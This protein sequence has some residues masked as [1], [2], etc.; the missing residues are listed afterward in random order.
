MTDF[1][2][3][4]VHHHMGTLPTS[5]SQA[6]AAAPED[7][8]ATRTA[9]MDKYGFEAGLAMPSLSYPRPRGF[10]DTQAI[11]DDIAGYRDRHSARFPVALGTVQPTDPTEM[12][13]N[14]L[15]RMATDLKLDGVV[16]HHRYQGCHLSDRRMHPLLDA[17]AK[18]NMVAFFHVISDSN[19]EAPF[20]LEELYEAHPDV[21]F[22][23]LD[24][25]TSFTQIRF[26]MQMAKRCPKLLFDTALNFPVASSIE[27]FVRRFGSER[28]LFGTDMYP[29][30]MYVYP[31]VLR[32]VLDAPSLSDDDR[33]N[34]FWNNAARLFPRGF[35][36]LGNG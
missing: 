2:I 12:S 9:A 8:Y 10:A 14:E 23:A 27:E 36:K 15:A 13:V 4:D 24:S 35:A 30:H 32:E 26:I 16:W 11:N 18:H 21:T 28:L 6:A 19:M 3:F 34:I 1:R 25:M 20:L 17:C 29:A 31:H 33:R 7:D 22:V 5:A